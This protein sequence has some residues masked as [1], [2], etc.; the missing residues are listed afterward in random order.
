VYQ[1]YGPAWANVSNTPFRRFKHFTEE[2]GI[3]APFVVRW[4]GKTGAPGRV[5]R[6]AVGD[7]IDLMPTVLAMAGATYP[8]ERNG[9]EIVPAE[10]MNLVPVLAGERI[11]RTGPGDGALFWEHEGNRAVRLGDWKLVAGEGE[12]WHLYNVATDRAELNDLVAA[13]PAK[14]KELSDR[15]QAWAARCRVEPW[16]IRR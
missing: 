2:G 15:Y 14:V 8:K 16:P 1:S 3:S 11:E 6:G 13:E 4:P 12:A 7:V 9:K 10:G 5:E